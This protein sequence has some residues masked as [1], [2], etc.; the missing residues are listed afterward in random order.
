[1]RFIARRR[2]LDYAVLATVASQLPSFLLK[3]S[4]VLTKQMVPT[5]AALIGA[6]RCK[7]R[8][9]D[10]FLTRGIRNVVI[11]ILSLLDK[12]IKPF[13]HMVARVTA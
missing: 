7:I 12:S 10:S 2:I 9:Y 8:T 3:S 6:A 1:M 13:H 5:R 11:T 4:N